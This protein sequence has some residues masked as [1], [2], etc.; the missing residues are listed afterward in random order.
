M[1]IRDVTGLESDSDWEEK[2]FSGNLISF[3]RR[4]KNRKRGLLIYILL[5]SQREKYL[6]AYFHIYSDGHHVHY[7]LLTNGNW[8]PVVMREQKTEEN[9]R[10]ERKCFLFVT[11]KGRR[12]LKKECICKKKERKRK[13]GNRERNERREEAVY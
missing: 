2:P 13:G 12:D 9:K 6:V 4:G 7:V 8:T 10:G 1:T 3:L 5:F 11:E